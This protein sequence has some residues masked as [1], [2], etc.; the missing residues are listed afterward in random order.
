M[1]F[2]VEPETFFLT[3]YNLRNRLGLDYRYSCE[4]TYTVRQN[5]ETVSERTV[6][7]I[8]IDPMGPGKEYAR[9]YLEPDS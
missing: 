5:G 8:G 7:Y 6:S 9:A 1:A 3:N 2:S 4:V